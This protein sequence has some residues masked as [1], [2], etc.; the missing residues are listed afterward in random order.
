M[1]NSLLKV[2]LPMGVWYHVIPDTI[3][4]RWNITQYINLCMK[5]LAQWKRQTSFIPYLNHKPSFC[6]EKKEGNRQTLC[7]NKMG[8]SREIN[9]SLESNKS[10]EYCV[11]LWGERNIINNK[12]GCGPCGIILITAASLNINTVSF[13]G[14]IRSSVVTELERQPLRGFHFLQIGDINRVYLKNN[15]SKQT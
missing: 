13:R 8:C 4:R 2:P 1:I 5:Y 6:S 14:I 10:G 11:L 9:H 12:D 15:K 7:Q 3:F